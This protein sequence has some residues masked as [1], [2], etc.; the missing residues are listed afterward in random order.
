[1]PKLPAK[2][3][4]IEI[5]SKRTRKREEAPILDPRFFNTKINLLKHVENYQFLYDKDKEVLAERQA[6]GQD[7][8]EQKAR[9]AARERLIRLQQ[10]ERER[11]QLEAEL[12]KEGK[13]PFYLSSKRKRILQAM[14]TAKDKGVDAVVSRLKKKEKAKEN[15]SR[16]IISQ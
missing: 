1:M 13:K 2:R 8:K 16:E 11:S 12:V 9:I 7:I 15:K 6:Q 4:P 14:E 3:T 5:S 10:A